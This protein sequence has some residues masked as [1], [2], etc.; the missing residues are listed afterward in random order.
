M[1]RK[2]VKMQTSRFTIWASTFVFHHG[3]N[4]L[5]VKHALV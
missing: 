1:N 5:Y 3:L 4:N 2:S